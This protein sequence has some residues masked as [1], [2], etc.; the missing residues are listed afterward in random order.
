M[1]E[2]SNEQSLTQAKTN[3]GLVPVR[4]APALSHFG[5]PLKGT[6]LRAER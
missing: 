3:P 1:L 5:E 6:H 2:A 4:A